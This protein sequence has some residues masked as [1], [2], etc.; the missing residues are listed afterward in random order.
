M[1]PFKI[2]LLAQFVQI[3]IQTQNLLVFDHFNRESAYN[4]VDFID[5]L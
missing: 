3:V 4:F 1:K 2:V 5:A